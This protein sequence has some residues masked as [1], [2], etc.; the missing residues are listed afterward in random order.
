MS[1]T[2]IDYSQTRVAEVWNHYVHG[3]VDLAR[4]RMLDLVYDCD[5]TE[6][7]QRAVQLSITMRQDGN[8]EAVANSLHSILELADAVTTAASPAGTLLTIKDVHKSYSKGAFSLKSM[9]LTL[10]AGQIIGVVGENGN[11]KT[12]LLRC[13]AGQL[14]GAIDAEAYSYLPES[15]NFFYNLKQHT[16]FIPQRIPKWHGKLRDNL[17]FSAAIA[18][19]LG[20]TGEMMVDFMLERFGLAKFSE[21]TWNQ[22][23]SGYRTRFEIARVVLQRPRLLILDEPLANLDINAQQTL[24][25]DLRFLA[26]SNRHPMGVVIT[27][28]QLYEIEKISDRVLFIKNGVGKYNDAPV[29]S[30]SVGDDLS[31]NLFVIELECNESREELMK[32]LGD[33][34]ADIRFNGGVYQITASAAPHELLKRIVS[35]GVAPVYYRDISLSTKRFF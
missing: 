25:Q 11:G 10:S 15:V 30:N 33:F 7:L 32:A 22:I 2:A 16:G 20:K 19:L 14:D 18:G 27:S 29:A 12:T 6:L 23:S 1:T 28:Q 4:R 9:D 35:A 26:Q 21:L 34:D 3:D 17:L 8:T 31:K 13:I 24:L 5:H